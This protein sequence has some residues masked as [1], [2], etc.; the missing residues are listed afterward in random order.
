[1]EVKVSGTSEEIQ[2]TIPGRII[3]APQVLRDIVHQ[4]IAQIPGVARLAPVRVGPW[5]LSGGVRLTVIED[6]V[7]IDLA[8]VVRP[9]V[10]FRE[11]AR[12]VQEEVARAIRD[13][14]G[15]EVAA[16]NVLIADVEVEERGPSPA[17]G[18]SGRA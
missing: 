17:S 8:L 16:V 10:P 18:S 6:R 13:L 4:T 12:Q 3:I 5:S 2:E 7:R 11:I 9:D 15:L 1:M 14:T